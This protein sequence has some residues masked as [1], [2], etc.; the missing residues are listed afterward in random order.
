M[1]ANFPPGVQ[2]SERI[3]P[4]QAEILTADALAFVADLH[5]A[6]EPRRNQLLAQRVEQA[7]VL[8]ETITALIP[9]KNDAQA[10]E[11]ALDDGRKVSKAMFREMLPQELAGVRQQWGEVAYGAGRYDEG[12]ALFDRITTSDEFVEFL[13][14][15]AY[16][17]IE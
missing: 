10:N 8:V 14:L 1:I 2:V 11:R 6:F 13:T 5:R 12:A 17:M 16:E 3:T 9:N 15:P 7:T 4:E